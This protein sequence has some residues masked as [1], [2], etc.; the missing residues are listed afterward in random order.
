MPIGVSNDSGNNASSVIA[1]LSEEIRETKAERAQKQ[2]QNVVRAAGQ[3][4]S[5]RRTL[6]NE[7]EDTWGVKVAVT[8]VGSQGNKSFAM[9]MVNSGVSR[10]V[11][12]SPV[13]MQRMNNE[14]EFRDKVTQN[15]ADTL[16]SM[17]SLMTSEP[18]KKVSYG[19]LVDDEGNIS[20]WSYV[21]HN[22]GSEESSRYKYWEE[23]KEKIKEERQEKLEE[24][25]ERIETAGGEY[26]E[27]VTM[28]NTVDIVMS[29]SVK[30][31]IIMD[32]M[33]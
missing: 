14:P 2:T 16:K 3:V 26:F 33:G 13:A 15:V 1:R 18:G 10:S 21:E 11:G 22:V 28:N 8:A 9:G 12:I 32:I 17:D 31:S 27:P 7:L 25:Q 19:L 20:S 30:S 24:Q 4:G 23:Y 6:I 29:D 5:A